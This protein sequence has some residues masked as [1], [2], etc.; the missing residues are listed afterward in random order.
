FSSLHSPVGPVLLRQ[1][2]KDDF[3]NIA[4]T[5]RNLI[6]RSL[7]VAIRGD[8][9]G[10]ALGSIKDVLAT[11]D[12][13]HPFEYTFFADLLDQQYAGEAKVMRLTGIFAAL[14]IVI[15]CLGLFGLAAFM[16]EQRTK[17][18]GIRKVLGASAASIIFMLSRGLLILV[19]FAAVAASLAAFF[20][21][22]YWLATFAYR[23][24]IQ[25]DI[26]VMATLLISVLAFLSVALQAGRT[27]Q[28]NPIDA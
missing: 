28:Q 4:P 11:F 25:V 2:G 24:H 23:T 12:P 27:A 17:E 6:T 14:C 3:A 5:A 20:V 10:A 22:Q 15:S 21:M 7:V 16:T 26:F 19:L 8:Q 9:V 18:I 1:F 13:K